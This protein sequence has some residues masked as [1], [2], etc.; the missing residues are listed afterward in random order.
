MRVPEMLRSDR[1][2]SLPGGSGEASQS[3]ANQIKSI[4]ATSQVSVPAASIAAA[5][6]TAITALGHDSFGADIA[7]C[8]PHARAAAPLVVGRP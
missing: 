3:V 4:A 7:G 5:V 1:L 2:A 6:A 8:A